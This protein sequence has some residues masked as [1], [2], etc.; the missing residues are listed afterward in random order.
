MANESDSKS[1]PNGQTRGIWSDL[2][3]RAHKRTLSVRAAKRKIWSNQQVAHPLVLT[4]TPRLQMRMC[5]RSRCNMSDMMTMNSDP[6][7]TT[8]EPADFIGGASE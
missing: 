5:I 2:A 4:K 8:G 7:V 1:K 6:G 3:R